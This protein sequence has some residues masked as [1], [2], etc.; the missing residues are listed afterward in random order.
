M[1]FWVCQ[2]S[3]AAMF[4][5]VFTRRWIPAY[6]GMTILLS[7]SAC[8][9]AGLSLPSLGWFP[10]T[11]DNTE[12]HQEIFGES[13]RRLTAYYLEPVD[14]AQ[15]V[16]QGLAGLRQID[17]AYVPTLA[18]PPA[19]ATDW[20]SWG[21]L[22]LASINAAQA[23]SA[24][25]AQATPDQIY[26]AFYPALLA[27]L[28]GFSHYV[29]PLESK[30]A[31]DLREGYG[32]IGVTF[33]RKGPNFVVIDTYID[34]PAAK[35]GM[36]AGQ[37][38]YAINGVNAESLSAIE[39]SEKV[40]GAVGTSVTLTIGK[41]GE[42]RRDVRIIRQHVVPNTVS[43][44][45][46]RTVAVMRISRFMPGTVNEFRQD[47][48]QAVWNH[49]TAVVLDLQRNP[50]GILESATEIASLLVPR[51]VVSSTSGRN[52]DALHTY[53]SNGADVL[54]G[55]PLY[56]LMDG[57]SASAAEVLAAALKDRGRATLVG[58]TSYG[59][60]SVQNVGPLPHGG[61][62]AVT[63]ARLLSPNGYSWVHTGLAPNVCVVTE[64]P[65]PKLDDIS[66]LA[67]P[68]ALELARQ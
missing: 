37:I 52:R 6:A 2:R 47:A 39:F 10:T 32:G 67:L 15:L 55:L 57:H 44:R 66:A 68:K 16:P 43:L 34:S 65:C 41:P 14:L 48:R 4:K 63:W 46:D 62:I 31:D 17:P 24:L 40:R 59:K 56:V 36:S 38:V 49:A 5:Q 61:E 1:A 51:G 29:P 20:R 9:G 53:S 60:G 58:S 50:G 3:L 7:L 25:L 26:E 18:G 35:A 64:N 30:A 11:L 12:L 33:E 54:D 23:H 21:N 8:S 28:D 13:Y 45:M 22:T 19:G 27:P 42:D